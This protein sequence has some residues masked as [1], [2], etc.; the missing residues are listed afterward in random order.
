M[1]Q[2]KT[3]YQ[4]DRKSMTKFYL[5]LF[6]DIMNIAVNNACCIYNDLAKNPEK[7]ATRALKNF[8][9]RQIIA[10]DLIGDYSN[11]QRK[12]LQPISGKFS[13]STAAKPEYIMMKTNQR[14]RCFECKKGRKENRTYNICQ[15]CQ[16]YLCYRTDRNCFKA[17]HHH[18][19]LTHFWW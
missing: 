1:D 19:F 5:R 16:V 17:Y 3:T 12:I 11:R 4:N 14:N 13:I 8:E 15:T 18:W 10:R 7:R 2:Q 6:F 9:Y